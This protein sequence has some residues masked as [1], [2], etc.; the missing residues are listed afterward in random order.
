MVSTVH[1]PRRMPSAIGFGRSRPDS[2]RAPRSFWFDPRFAIGVGLVIVSVLGVVGVVTAAD[3]SVLVYAARS[4]LVP[5][6]RVTPGDL[7]ARSV[8]LGSLGVRYLREG[9]VP[10][11][12]FVVTRPV[13]A[14]ELVPSSALG[15][16]AG[17][18]GAPVVVGVNG[19]LA[20]SIAEGSIVDLW[21]AKEADDHVFGPPSVLVDSATVVRVIAKD[22]VIVDRTVQ[23]VELLVPRT[24]IAAVLESIANSDALSLV[25][26]S[27]PAKG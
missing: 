8:R 23:S 25:P 7:D 15:E 2:E 13:S 26:T 20:R 1:A 24:K 11:E 27:I 21:S 22:G 3:S 4:A 16:V 18:V 14:G 17:A 9:D 6:D 5:G 10:R 19:E 12:G